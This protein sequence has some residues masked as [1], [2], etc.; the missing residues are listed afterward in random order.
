LKTVQI[1][2]ST[3][4]NYGKRDCGFLRSKTRKYA[5]EMPIERPVDMLRKS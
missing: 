1:S 5:R 2:L 3:P 4:E